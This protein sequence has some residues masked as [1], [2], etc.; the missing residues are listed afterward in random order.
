M[1]RQPFAGS[2]VRALGLAEGDAHVMRNAG[3]VFA[4]DVPRSLV[5]PQRLLGT[6]EIVLVQ[7]AD[8]GMRTFRDDDVKTGRIAEVV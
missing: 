5:I 4:E 7:H 3:G 8:C 1:R 6:E 2:Q